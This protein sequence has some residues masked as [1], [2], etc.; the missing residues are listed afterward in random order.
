MFF[1]LLSVILIIVLI[2]LLFDYFD[3][4]KNWFGR[5]KIGQYTENAE[6]EE[7]V[8]KIIVKWSVNGAPKVCVNENKKL[9]VADFV[10]EKINGKISAPSYWQEAAVLKAA[11]EMG[12]I[13][14]NDFVERFINIETGEWIVKP[15]RIDSAILC[16]EFMNCDEID[17]DTVKPALDFV[18]KMISYYAEKDG[19]VAYNENVPDYRFVDTVGL[20]CPFL[21]KYALTFD[22]K[23][24]IEIAMKQIKEFQIKG[25]DDNTNLPFH[26]YDKRNGNKLG[27]CGWGRG[28]A[29]WIYGLTES[30]R[31][32]IKAD[33]YD[34]EKAYLLR[35]SVDALENIKKYFC[36]D[37]SVGRSLLV[38]N[39][40]Q[41]N[42][43]AAML[44]YCFKYFAKL[45]ENEGYYSVAE[46]VT[47]NLKCSTRRNGIIDY[48]QGDTSAIGFYSDSLCV[49][50]AAQGF[51]VC[52]LMME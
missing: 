51:A 34:A 23:S 39:S 14:C 2:G 7:A 28:C 52:T 35:L 11:N 26:C 33:G 47:E 24:L 50:P 15:S 19:T 16:Y 43:A 41:D 5:I 44:A 3:L 45:T 40:L 36:E 38:D 31:S 37:G 8:K 30:L 20:I 42:S 17:N 46:S 6:W 27:I 25:I 22:N 13:D 9:K 10:K 1:I 32:L 12:D 48:S 49:I 21:I 18:V 29:W 4:I